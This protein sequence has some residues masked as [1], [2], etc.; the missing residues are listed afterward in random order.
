MAAI[1]PAS[2]PETPISNSA[3]RFGIR[4]RIEI[5]APNVPIKLG[6]GIKYGRLASTPW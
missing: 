5:T 3:L 6:T 4:P 2:G 1:R